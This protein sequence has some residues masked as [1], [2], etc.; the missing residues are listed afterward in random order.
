MAQRSLGTHT[1]RYMKLC[2]VSVLSGSEMDLW[3][4]EPFLDL[5]PNIEKLF[6]PANRRRFALMS[7]KRV[8]TPAARMQS[9]KN[10][11]F[12][13]Y[14]VLGLV[15]KVASWRRLCRRMHGGHSWALGAGRCEVANVD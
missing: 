4:G 8:T 7:W 1:F 6:M 15:K 2:D 11:K 9:T 12:A 5:E 10:Q 3:F 13:L 14:S